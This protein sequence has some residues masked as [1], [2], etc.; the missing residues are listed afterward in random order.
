MPSA[1]ETLKHRQGDC[2]EHAVLL[3]AL[4]RASGIPATYGSGA[5]PI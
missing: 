5:G 3:T 4:A 1:L 2:N